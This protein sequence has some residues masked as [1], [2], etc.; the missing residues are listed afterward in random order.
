ML[1]NP[2]SAPPPQRAPL[3][4]GYTPV[5]D[6]SA[7]MQDAVGHYAFTPSYAQQVNGGDISG[8][9]N[10][11]RQAHNIFWPGVA[12]DLTTIGVGALGA[13]PTAAEAGAIR[14]A[15]SGA[16]P[17]LKTVAKLGSAAANALWKQHKANQ[18]PD[19]RTPGQDRASPG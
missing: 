18:R 7:Y 11:D 17:G 2:P 8:A 15:G 16:L 13:G 6:G 12:R 9:P 4:P 5:G 10:P 19:P 14:P 1:R 3:P